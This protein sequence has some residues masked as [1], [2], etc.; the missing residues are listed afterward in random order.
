MLDTLKRP[1][2]GSVVFPAA[3]LLLGAVWYTAVSEPSV[4]STETASGYF[5]PQSSD[6]GAATGAETRGYMSQWLHP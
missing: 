4:L 6:C 3:L 5:K 1:R 2:R